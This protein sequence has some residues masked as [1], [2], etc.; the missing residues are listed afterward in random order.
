MGGNGMLHSRLWPKEA[1]RCY[2]DLLIHEYSI[3]YVLMKEEFNNEHR[4]LL[5]WV[6]L[7]ARYIFW[8]I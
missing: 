2:M 4:S 1:N 6:F 8:A 7:Q 3:Q 5:Q